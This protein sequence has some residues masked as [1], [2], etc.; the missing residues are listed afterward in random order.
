MFWTDVI[1]KKTY[2]EII[3]RKLFNLKIH[4]LILKISSWIRSR[5]CN[6]LSTW[7]KLFKKRIPNQG[8]QADLVKCILKT[9]KMKYLQIHKFRFKNVFFYYRVQNVP[10]NSVFWSAAMK[11]SLISNSSKDNFVKKS[12]PLSSKRKLSILLSWSFPSYICVFKRC[13]FNLEMRNTG[14]VNNAIELSLRT[15]V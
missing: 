13:I 9:S 2:R 15:F 5:K 11:M 14:L 4:K 3:S 8:A 10:E 1:I 7:Q 12:L 6:R